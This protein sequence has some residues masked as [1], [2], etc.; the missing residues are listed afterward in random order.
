MVIDN[1]QQGF[2]F[3]IGHCS[4]EVHDGM[5]ANLEGEILLICKSEYCQV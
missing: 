2:A 1:V 5:V 4:V 3:D